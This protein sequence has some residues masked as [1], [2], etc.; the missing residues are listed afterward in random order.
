MKRS[1]VVIC[2]LGLLLAT[3]MAGCLNSY[4][5]LQDGVDF[6]QEMLEEDIPE[7]LS[8]SIYYINP[9]ILTRV[10]L[11][12]DDLIKFPGVKKIIIESQDLEEHMTLLKKMD[13]TI[14][15]PVK[16]KSYI[17]ARLYYVFEVGSSDKILEVAINQLH[18]SVFVNG[19]E[20][21]DN[22]LFYDI[23]IP[24]L[25]EDDLNILGIQH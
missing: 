18:G 4:T 25:T 1:I 15:H 3:S 14:L 21:E 24:F 6:Y 8:L 20:V 7:D 2:L 22:Q 9:S 5:Q 13:S 11:S 16:E 17:N 12:T 19:V 23:I 10:P